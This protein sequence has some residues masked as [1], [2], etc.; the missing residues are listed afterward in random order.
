MYSKAWAGGT[1]TI[2]SLSWEVKR[3]VKAFSVR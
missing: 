1:K 3:F 2:S